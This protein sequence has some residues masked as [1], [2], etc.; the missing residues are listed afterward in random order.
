MISIDSPSSTILVQISIHVSRFV[1]ELSQ[2]N[3]KNE[4][5]VSA[6]SLASNAFVPSGLLRGGMLHFD[7]IFDLTYDQKRFGLFLMFSAIFISKFTLKF[8]VNVR[9]SFLTIIYLVRSYTFPVVIQRF[10]SFCFKFFFV[11][12]ICIHINVVLPP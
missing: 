7:F 9:N 12:S 11:N 5:R 2:N 8:L 1:T 3:A 10:Q 4:F 6:L